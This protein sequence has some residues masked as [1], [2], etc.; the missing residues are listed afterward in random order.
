MDKS[1][2]FCP[3]E[4]CKHF[5]KINEGNL[6]VKQTQGKCQPIDL[7]ICDECETTFSE[8]KGT[9]YFGIKKPDYVFDQ[10]IALLMTRISIKDIVRVTGVSEDTIGKWITK[11]SSFLE[12]I[13]EKL[14]RDLNITECQ[15]DEMWTYVLMKNKTVK[16]KNL[17]NVDDKI[18]D[19]WIFIAFDAVNKLVIHWKVGKRTLERAKMFIKEVKSKIITNP[20]YTSDELPAYEEAFLSNFSE[21]IV[22]EKTGK[23]GRPRKKALRKVDPDLKLAQTHKD[24]ENGK[25]VNVTEEIIFG[26]EEEIRK[27]LKESPVSNCIN[28]SFVER[29]NGTVRSKV[30]R[31]VRCTYSFSKKYEKHLA[32]LAIYFVYY[33]FIWIHS[34]IKKTAACM[35][36]IVDK[37]FTFNELFNMRNLEFICGH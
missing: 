6:R 13:S 34:R 25:V 9:V 5:H 32:H 14:L 29:N 7:M 16:K 24:R 23:R 8:R 12:P 4:K 2:I 18:G 20:L 30:S 28:T 33:N 21:E 15:V 31:T 17:E 35:S 36:G 19:Q 3:N 10:V 1:M 22:I 27:I 37:A 26:D 11:A